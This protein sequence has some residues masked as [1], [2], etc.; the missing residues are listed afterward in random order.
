MVCRP[1]WGQQQGLVFL[2]HIPGMAPGASAQ[3]AGD[4]KEGGAVLGQRSNQFGQTLSIGLIQEAVYA[5]LDALSKGAQVGGEGRNAQCRHF[6][7]SVA[8]GLWQGGEEE[9]AIRRKIPDQGAKIGEIVVCDG[10]DALNVGEG[11]AKHAA[12]KQ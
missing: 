8:E 3:V 9:G 2:H 11:L 7:E 6:A 5:M 10:G 12:A 4:F 1:V